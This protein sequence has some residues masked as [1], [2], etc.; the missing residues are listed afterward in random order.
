MRFFERMPEVKFSYILYHLQIATY[1]IASFLAIRKYKNLLLENYSNASM[2]SYR[3][4]YQLISIY[5]IS[6]IVASVKWKSQR[7]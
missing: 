6:S 3:W 7:P 4:M 1:L 5:A 2:F